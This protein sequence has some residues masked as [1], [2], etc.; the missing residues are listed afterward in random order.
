MLPNIDTA[1]QNGMPVESY[2]RGGE[3]Q[4]PTSVRYKAADATKPAEGGSSSATAVV[5][6]K[7]RS[8]SDN[9]TDQVT[10]NLS[11]SPEEKDAFG[12]AFS[13]KG[14]LSTMSEEEKQALKEASERI[15]KFIDDTVSKNQDKREK[16][17]KAVREWYS[18][19]TKG[20]ETGPTEFIS[21]LRAAAMGTLEEQEY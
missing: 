3:N 18:R 5:A 19:I 2:G 10:I 1:L 17:E 12:K 4:R 13:D 8:E 9:R 20:K 11:L 16:V 6:E 15:G 7:K 21:L 14:N